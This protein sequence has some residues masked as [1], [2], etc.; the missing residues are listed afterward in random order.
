MQGD[1]NTAALALSALPDLQ[2]L[3]LY[4]NGLSGTLGE[5]SDLC[6]LAQGSLEMMQ[7]GGMGLSGTLPTCLFNA[8]SKLYQAGGAGEGVARCVTCRERG[9]ATCRGRQLALSLAQGGSLKYV[10]QLPPL[11]ALP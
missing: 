7:L 2:E 6:R 3:G 11:L 9:M 5:G 4:G 1:I 8:T 10:C